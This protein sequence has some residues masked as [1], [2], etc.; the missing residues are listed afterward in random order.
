MGKKISI[1]IPVYNAEKYLAQC[2]ESI[3]KQ[4]Y[5]NLEIII[6]NDGSTD[7]SLEIC[8]FYKENDQRIVV[9][10]QN[11][12]GVSV[13]RNKGLDISN[14]EFIMFVDADD[15]LNADFVESLYKVCEEHVLVIGD[16]NEKYEDDCTNRDR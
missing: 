7:R 14:G 1:I 10:N 6:I 9:F 11:N 13:A 3:I 2:I 4:T 15:W 12:S 16:F 8:N 5:S